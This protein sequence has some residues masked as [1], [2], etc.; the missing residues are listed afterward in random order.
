MLRRIKWAYAL[1]NIFKYK[2]LK[3]NTALYKSLG[4][5][6]WYFSPISSRDFKK[7]D[8][9]NKREVD[10]KALERSAI[11]E[12]I[13][14][15]SQ[16]S[17]QQYDENGYAILKSYISKEKVDEI[18]NKIDGLLASGEI[19]F[20]YGNKLM[21]AIHHSEILRSIARDPKLTELLDILLDGKSTLFQSIN[22][23]K[24][25]EQKSHS[26]SVHMTT[27]PLG[28]LLGVWIALEDIDAENGGLHY[29]PGSHKLPYYL[30]SDYDNEGTWLMLGKYDYTAYEAM[31]EAK[32]QQHGIEKKVFNAKAGD[33]LIWHANLL[34]GGEAHTDTSRTRKS[35]VF[36][37]FDK[38]S[39]C[40]H[41][42]TQRPA[43]MRF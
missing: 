33:V 4:L 31:I 35:M 40:Y 26:D 18:N 36:H 43:L 34:H 37:Y 13:D 41:E 28:G 2:K 38:N 14:R 32:I 16:L 24:G 9:S 8:V 1:Y 27:Y 25:S 3:H 42:I 6:K 19:K 39:I 11:F 22:F 23:L 12:S 30:N 20:R 10:A 21:F 17:L 7:L 5:R 29:Y 15:D